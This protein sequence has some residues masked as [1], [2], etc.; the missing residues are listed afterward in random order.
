LDVQNVDAKAM[1]LNV[2]KTIL[3]L[4]HS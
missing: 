1:I 4:F 3:E 2:N